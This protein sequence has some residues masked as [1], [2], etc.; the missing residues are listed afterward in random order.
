MAS[1]IKND[2]GLPDKIS[3]GL[4]RQIDKMQ[5]IHP[6][7][8]SE[9]NF[10]KNQE[11]AWATHL[12]KVQGLHA[13]LKLKMERKAVEH[14]GHFP[15]ISTRSNLLMDVLKG[16]D[17]SVSFDDVFGQPEHYEGM[18]QPHDSINKTVFGP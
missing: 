9:R 10:D 6:I 17:G 14:A 11:N 16:N 13:P 4:G 8:M 5:P 3:Q 7:E 1:A 2:F 18:A 12:K 15:C